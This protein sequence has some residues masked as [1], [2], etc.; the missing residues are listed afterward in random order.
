MKKSIGYPFALI[1]SGLG[2]SVIVSAFERFSQPYWMNCVAGVATALVVGYV[3][4]TPLRRS[5]GW[6]TFVWPLASIAL[7]AV[8]FGVLSATGFWLL[9]RSS[10]SAP[11]MP[12]MIILTP[13]VYLCVSLSYLI[14]ATYPASLATHLLLR[15]FALAAKP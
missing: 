13:W 2:W 4:R 14:W 5:H 15:R 11:T 8:T 9:G 6:L 7:G 1:M 10:L 3:M 12:E